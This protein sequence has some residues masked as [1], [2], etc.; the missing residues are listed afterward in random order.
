MTDLATAAHARAAGVAARADRP[1]ERRSERGTSLHAPATTA[2]AR[3]GVDSR[4]TDGSASSTQIGG[5]ASV[6]ESPYEMY[7]FFGPYTEVVSRGAFAVTLA[8]SPLVEY[9]L[10]HG[11]TGSGIPMAHTRNGTLTLAEDDTGL[12][13]LATVDPRR[14][15]VADVLLA[16]SRGDLAEASFKFSITA[17]TWSPDYTEFRIAQ[18][19]IEHGDVSTVNFGANPAATSALRAAI[20]KAQTGRALD[21][22]D[23]NMLTQALGWFT[24]L[25][26]IVDEA[27]ESLAAYLKVPNPDSCDCCGTDCACGDCAACPM[28]D[29]SASAASSMTFAQL[30]EA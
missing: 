9:T 14:T 5:Y 28:P 2:F 30:L 24:A 18:V 13:Y 23:V 26:M 22:E 29:Q 20:G 27:Q 17:G 19:D 15:D 12:S 4:A 21:P 25:D 7:D 16:L 3:I 6:T 8:T 1:R 10:N 11:K